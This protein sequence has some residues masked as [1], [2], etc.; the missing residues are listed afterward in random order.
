[1]ALSN[2]MGTFGDFIKNVADAYKTQTVGR[3]AQTPRATKAQAYEPISSS[4]QRGF[5]RDENSPTG[6]SFAS[7]TGTVGTGARVPTRNPYHKV[8]TAGGGRSG[9]A[10][11][12]RSQDPLAMVGEYADPRSRTVGSIPS[13][14][15]T[16]PPGGRSTPSAIRSSSGS[17]YGPL[18][19]MALT[20]P[21][22]AYSGLMPAIH[23]GARVAYR[24]SPAGRLS[25][26]QNSVSMMPWGDW[27]NQVGEYTGGTYR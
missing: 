4:Q 1:M 13:G 15:R 22:D 17:D 8:L 12:Y 21:S 7:G 9:M 10:M 11:P 27:F 5:F 19:L 20:P 18:E 23:H 24:Y 26:L 2:L 6:W 3:T 14:G 25:N 16:T